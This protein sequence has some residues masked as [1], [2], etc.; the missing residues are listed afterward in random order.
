MLDKADEFRLLVPP[1]HAAPVAGHRVPEI[2][3]GRRGATA[4]RE[5]QGD[6]GAA[7]RDQGEAGQWQGEDGEHWQGDGAELGAV[8]G[9]GRHGGGGDQFGR[10]FAR[11]GQPRDGARHL[12]RNDDNGRH[13]REGRRHQLAAQQN[14][15][16]GDGVDDLQAELGK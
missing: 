7:P 9:G 2:E 5:Q 13:Q 8:D 11:Y 12:R 1:Q 15:G 14:H 16:D 4:G 6:G 10:V 3:Q